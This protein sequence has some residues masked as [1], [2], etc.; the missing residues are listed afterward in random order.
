M[1]LWYTL[2]TG[3][4]AVFSVFGLVRGDDNAGHNVLKPLYLPNLSRGSPSRRAED[5]TVLD[6]K[7]SETLLWGNPINGM[8]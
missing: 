4:C 1:R 7:S 3:S 6:P 8:T 2:L 5:F